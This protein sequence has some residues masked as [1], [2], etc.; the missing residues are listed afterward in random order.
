MASIDSGCNND[1]DLSIK[2]VDIEV[3]DTVARNT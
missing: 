3:A 1:E 2:N